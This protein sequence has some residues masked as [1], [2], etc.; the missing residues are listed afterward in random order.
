[1]YLKN[2]K[3][4]LSFQLGVS[5]SVSPSSSSCAHSLL[6]HGLPLALALS[7]GTTL[8]LSLDLGSPLTH[9]V[10]YVKYKWMLPKIGIHYLS[11]SLKTHHGVQVGLA[12]DKRL[13]IKQ[14]LH[15]ICTAY[16]EKHQCSI[17]SFL[18]KKKFIL[19]FSSLHVNRYKTE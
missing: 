1:M 5:S 10:L 14:V 2:N 19:W 17:N 18:K 15:L 9:V 12:K 16:G 4:T 3:K 6:N 8:N 11:W 13:I 7:D